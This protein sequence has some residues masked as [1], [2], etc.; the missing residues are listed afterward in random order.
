MTRSCVGP[1]QFST[2]LY[3]DVRCLAG[4]MS[5]KVCS[6]GVDFRSLGFD[7]EGSSEEDMSGIDD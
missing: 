4:A 2:Y 6:E 1:S 7:A 5:G 3:C